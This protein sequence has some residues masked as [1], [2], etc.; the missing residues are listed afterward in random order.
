MITYTKKEFDKLVGAYTVHIL[1]LE[2]PEETVLKVLWKYWNLPTGTPAFVKKSLT[3]IERARPLIEICVFDHYVKEGKN[4]AIKGDGGT[5]CESSFMTIKKKVKALEPM[6]KRFYNNWKE[7]ERLKKIKE[8]TARISKKKLG[9]L[10]NQINEVA[11]QIDRYQEK[12]RDAKERMK[13]LIEQ[14]NT[15]LAQQDIE[16]ETSERFYVGDKVHWRD[17][18]IN[19]FEPEDRAGQLAIVWT[20]AEFQAEEGRNYATGDDIVLLTCDTGECEAFAHELS[21]AN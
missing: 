12:M 21:H 3:D 17:P 20:V 11:H 1:G 16:N 18:A 9:S 2:K 19:D 10:N 13:I 4:I 15:L 7:E 6:V 5:V 8:N 14:R